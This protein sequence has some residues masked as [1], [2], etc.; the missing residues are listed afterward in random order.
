MTIFDPY[1]GLDGAGTFSYDPG[2]G[3]VSLTILRKEPAQY[4]WQKALPLDWGYSGF[5]LMSRS[6]AERGNTAISVDR[7]AVTFSVAGF[8]GSRKAAWVEA[9]DGT[10][11]SATFESPAIKGLRY[12]YVANTSS[13]IGADNLWPWSTSTPVE[14]S[15]QQ[16][17]KP[18][19]QQFARLRLDRVMKKKRY[20]LQTNNCTIRP[21]NRAAC[22]LAYQVGKQRWGF[23]VYL[24]PDSKAM[25]RG[26]AQWLVKSTKPRK[27][28]PL[29]PTLP[30]N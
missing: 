27:L 26:S 6:V 4:D 16:L 17:D 23:S 13:G 2:V 18:S 22:W 21:S 1:S 30:V 9:P 12:Q 28:A 24:R 11:M 7:E 29:L 19:S 20:T 15:L 8:A 5:E 25:L 10:S 14:L 3:Q